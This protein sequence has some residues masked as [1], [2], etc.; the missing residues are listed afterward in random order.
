MANLRRLAEGNFLFFALCGAFG[1]TYPVDFKRHVPEGYRAAVEIS[2]SMHDQTEIFRPGSTI[3]NAQ[4]RDLSLKGTMIVKRVNANGLTDTFQFR[5]NS[6]TETVGQNRYVVI[7]TGQELTISSEAKSANFAEGEVMPD[8][9]ERIGFCFR[10]EVWRQAGPPK[11]QPIGG[12]WTVERDELQQCLPL[13]EGFVLEK[14]AVGSAMLVAVT[15]FEGIVCLAVEFRASGNC[16]PAMSLD[17][18]LRKQNREFASA[19]F[20]AE[21]R[22]FF[23]TNTSRLGIFQT[24]D[25]TLSG[26]THLKG[27]PQIVTRRVTRIKRITHFPIAD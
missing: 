6:F 8:T 7:P 17:A 22:A 2:V 21:C 10:P 16:A 15:N 25:F 23:P 1:Q 27:S 18:E 14:N 11:P 13:P 20:V 4:D 5:I 3:T 19:D 9:K 24:I 26:T 12:S